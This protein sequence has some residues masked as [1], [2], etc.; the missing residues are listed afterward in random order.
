MKLKEIKHATA[1]DATLTA[2]IEVVRTNNWHNASKQGH[3]N[4]DKLSG[5]QKVCDELS[6]R[7]DLL[8]RDTQR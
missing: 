7:E 6:V 2:A 5:L 1:E 8:L 4:M 3:F